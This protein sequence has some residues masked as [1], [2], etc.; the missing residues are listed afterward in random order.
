MNRLPLEE[1]LRNDAV[2]VSERNRYGL[3]LQPV[4]LIPG[5]GDADDEVVP[6]H[7]FQRGSIADVA[8]LEHVYSEDTALA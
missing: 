2:I 3:R 1:V 8:R 5:E 6:E 4:D 7:I